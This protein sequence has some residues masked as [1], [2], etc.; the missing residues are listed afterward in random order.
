[1]ALDGRGLAWLPETLVRDDI[2]ASRLVPAAGDEWNV[3]LEIRLYREREPL[4][5]VAEAFWR[6]ATRDARA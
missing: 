1:M 2:A 5:P 4:G 6:S 3:P